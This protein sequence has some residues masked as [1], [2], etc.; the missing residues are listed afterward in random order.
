MNA[1]LIKQAALTVWPLHN[2]QFEV[3]DRV[4]GKRYGIM[5]EYEL[6]ELAAKRIAES[7]PAQ[8]VTP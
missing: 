1:Q 3:I 5:R 6:I 8:Q 4:T 7:R 2:H